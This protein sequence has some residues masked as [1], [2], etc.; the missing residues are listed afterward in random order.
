MLRGRYKRVY[1][2]PERLASDAFVAALG[3]CN[4][5]LVAVDE[6]HCIAQWGHDFR[7]D[8]PTHRSSLRKTAST[9][10]ARVHGDR[11]PR[12]AARDPPAAPGRRLP[13]GAP[14]LC[15]AE[16]ALGTQRRRSQRG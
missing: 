10:R 6:A 9:A 12:G 14:R 13:R 2:A 7:P 3:R 8:L 16:P 1:V 5:E 15:T 4:V 11:D